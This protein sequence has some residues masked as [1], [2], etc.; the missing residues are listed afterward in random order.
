[1]ATTLPP[2]VDGWFGTE[3]E[4]TVIPKPLF[5]FR[6]NPTAPDTYSRLYE[7]MYQ[8]Q[9]KLF[10]PKITNRTSWSNLV[11]YS[12][13]L[14]NAAWTKV[15]ATI[16][17]DAGTAP[18]GQ[19]TLDK[20]LETVTNGEH[21]VAQA[22]TVTA[23]VTEASFFAVGGLTRS[24][25]RLAFTDSAA[26]AFTGFFNIAS[27]YTGTASAGVTSIIVP[28][29]NNQFRCV[30]RFT[31]AAGAGTLKANISSD[32]ATISYAGNTA[33]GVY[34]WGG[35]VT[36]GSQTPYI[37]TTTATRTISAPDRDRTD[38]MAYLLE[39]E[40]PQMQTSQ[41]GTVRRLFGRIPRQQVIPDFRFVTKPEIP[42]TFPQTIGS[43]LVFQPISTVAS[44]DGYT[45]LTVTSDTGTVAATY[46]TGGTYTLTLDGDTT[47]ALNYNDNAATVEAALD[48][49][50]SVSDRGGVTVSGAYNTPGG[51]VVS[52]N[53]YANATADGSSLTGSPVAI[54][55]T[56]VQSESGGYVQTVTIKNLGSGALWN[57]GTFTVTVFG[58][59][60]GA[61][62]Y[63][64]S[65][66]T[67]QT[68][69]NALTEVQDRGGATVTLPNGQTNANTTIPYQITS[70][71][72]VF[73]YFWGAVRF[74]FSFANAVLTTSSSLTPSGSVLQPAITDGGVGQA[75]ALFFTGVP[76]GRT[77][78]TTTHTITASDDIFIMADGTPYFITAGGF[79]VPTPTT[80]TLS[81][82]GADFA[83]AAA[84]T[85]VGKLS[86][87]N[88]TP[89][90]KQTR[91][92]Q[93]TDSYL[94]GVTPGI[95]SITDIPLPVYQGD[96]ASLLEAIFEGSTSINYQVGELVQWRDTPILQRT[97]VTLNATQL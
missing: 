73:D 45:N 95:N 56:E 35:Q 29:G 36:T 51:L 60:T 89:G 80:I 17:A 33:N 34:L 21:S 8:V 79:T 37:S 91:C 32:G 38:P 59:T 48:L 90:L 67:I 50:A 7:R 49:L 20:V 86:I 4:L 11:T 46:P 96:P 27:G 10:L 76:G 19:T 58:Q 92:N 70:L 16:T 12:E 65:A 97:I 57:G 18:D 1:M 94:I 53:S 23:A 69:L 2:Y 66:A 24:W 3:Q 5:P 28:L 88:Y 42:G 81:T 61:I 77:I 14:D 84:I 22:A 39:E 15:N 25:I 44:Y 63:N 31:P 43:F 6:S 52:F 71:G 54:P 40:E 82:S 13:A 55:S 75:Q 85:A 9:P 30:I 87:E 93:V 41:S 72:I 47:G 26:T 83:T 78:G 62:A 68:A 64:A 74:T